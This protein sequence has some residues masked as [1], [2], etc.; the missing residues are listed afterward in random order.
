[1]A[2]TAPRTWV[3]GEIVTAAIM[4][5]HV[6]DNLLHIKTVG[7]LVYFE[8]ALASANLTLST[9][10][11]DVTG[12]THTYTT[13]ITNAKYVA[14]GVAQFQVSTASSGVN[15]RGYLNVDGTDRGTA[16]FVE[17]GGSTTVSDGTYSQCWEGPLATA[18]SHTLKMRG[19]KDAAG[20]THSIQSSHSKLLVAIYE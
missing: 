10:A 13:S 15:L 11:A 1:M 3:T 4:N 12:A 5:T 19:D 9:T 2:W 7:N 16:I 17:D 18:A 8:E 14:W 20:G 6:R